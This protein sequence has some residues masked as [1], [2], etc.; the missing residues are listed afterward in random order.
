MVSTGLVDFAQILTFHDG[1]ARGRSWILVVVETLVVELA[2]GGV[3][4]CWYVQAASLEHS[5]TRGMIL[6][7]S[8]LLLPHMW[9]P[10]M[11]E[12][13]PRLA[14]HAAW[15]LMEWVAATLTPLCHPHTPPVSNWST[16]R[17]IFTRAQVGC[18]GVL[19]WTICELVP[20]SPSPSHSQF[21]SDALVRRKRNLNKASLDFLARILTDDVRWSDGRR[22][23]GCTSDHDQ[24]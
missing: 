22:R 20:F 10:P 13:P 17:I 14:W 21:K 5:G 16:L 4:K 15:G 11:L 1:V 2:V 19:W 9:V 8:K 18:V 3:P 23:K 7:Y 12:L 6:L 24:P